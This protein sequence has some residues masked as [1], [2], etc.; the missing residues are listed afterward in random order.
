MSRRDFVRSAV[1]IGGGAALAACLDRES[2][3]DLPQGV[4]DPSE[5]PDRL[6]AWGDA[7]ATDD[8]GNDVAPR[9]QV[10]LYLDLTDD[11]PPG[12]DRRERVDRGLRTLERAYPRSNEGLLLTVGYS[13]AYFERF[14]A[15]GPE[16]ISLPDPEPL[17]PFEDPD[18]DRLDAV[19]TSRATTG[20]SF[21]PPRRRCSARSIPSTASA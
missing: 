19:Y 11:G 12:D 3:P 20:R 15:G 13:P 21:S 8:H 9:H 7:L 2:A 16:G 17:A 1:A 10:L 4:D 6:H 5:L 14:G 18:P